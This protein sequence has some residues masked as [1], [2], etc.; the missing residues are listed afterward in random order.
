VKTK[1]III[2]TSSFFFCS[3]SVPIHSSWRAQTNDDDDA[4]SIASTT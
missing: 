2:I 3:R 4:D 1:R